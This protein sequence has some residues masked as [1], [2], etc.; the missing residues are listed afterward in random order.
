MSDQVAHSCSSQK[1]NHIRAFQPDQQDIQQSPLQ[2]ESMLQDN[3]VSFQNSIAPNVI[4]ENFPSKL[5]APSA[6]LLNSPNQ[7]PISKSDDR[8]FPFLLKIGNCLLLWTLDV[9]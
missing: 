7:K 6:D 5:A 4:N 1:L 3:V 8:Q 2:M 9:I